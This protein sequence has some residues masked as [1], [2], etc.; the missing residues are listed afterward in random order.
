MND[1]LLVVTAV[2]FIGTMFYIVKITSE[3]GDVAK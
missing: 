1:L 2:F 3:I